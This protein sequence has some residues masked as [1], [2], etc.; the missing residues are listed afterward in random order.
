MVSDRRN[1]PMAVFVEFA[2]NYMVRRLMISIIF[3]ICLTTKGGLE[4]RDSY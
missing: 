2:E 4:V 3:V 1:Q